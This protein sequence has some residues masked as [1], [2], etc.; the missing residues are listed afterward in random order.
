MSPRTITA[1]GRSASMSAASRSWPSATCSARGSDPTREVVV[2]ARQPR[3]EDLPVGH[4]V[5]VVLAG[6]DEDLVDETVAAPR[7]RAPPG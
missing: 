2:G 1:S 4:R 6:V 7:T 5:V 3:G